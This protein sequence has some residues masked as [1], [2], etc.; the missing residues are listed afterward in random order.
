MRLNHVPETSAV[1]CSLHCM[2]PR[3]L[4]LSRT[5]RVA[6]RTATK[7]GAVRVHRSYRLPNRPQTHSPHTPF[8]SIATPTP[9]L[10]LYPLASHLPLSG[11]DRLIRLTALEA[12][13]GQDRAGL[14]TAP[15][16]TSNPCCVAG[17]G[18]TALHWFCCS[19]TAMAAGEPGSGRAG[20]VFGTRPGAPRPCRGSQ[21]G[22]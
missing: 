1:D 8:F 20:L 16:P 11:D 6:T 22:A 10:T 7:R 19:A 13:L 3:R 5:H 9:T 14:S 18:S 2:E 4:L 21:C 12:R 17:S 15:P